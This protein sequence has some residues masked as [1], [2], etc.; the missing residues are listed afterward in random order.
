MRIDSGGIITY[1]VSVQAMLPVNRT[2]SVVWAH[3]NKTTNGGMLLRCFF[4]FG[5]L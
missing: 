5:D 3:K 1:L 2:S 4:G